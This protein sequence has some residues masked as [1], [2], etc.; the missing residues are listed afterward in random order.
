MS[1]EENVNVISRF[2][3]EQFKVEILEH[4]KLNG[5]DDVSLGDTLYF[6]QKSGITLKQV[7][8][9]MKSASLTTETGALQFMK[10]NLEMESKMGGVGGLAK[11]MLTSALTDETIT[12]PVYKGSGEIHLEP[13][14]GHFIILKLHN[15]EVVVDQ[16]IFY[17]CDS[18]LAVS[19]IRQKNLV[20]GLIGGEGL[21]Q[22]KVSG[23][24]FLV[25]K[26]PVPEIEIKKEV[27]NGETL[28]VDGSFALLRKGNVEFTIQKSSK[29]LIGSFT[30]GEGLLQTF[31]GT[32]EVWLAPTLPAYN[33]IYLEDTDQDADDS[34]GKLSWIRRLGTVKYSV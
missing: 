15:E 23:T 33:E 29:S 14:F 8:I 3:N 34:P 4:Q 7:R 18:K 6:A 12:R 17:C 24:G 5:T 16:G 26:V 22:T 20:T 19:V 32:G 21:F 1:F 28:H 10:G 31:K 30:S 11:K 9:T 13:S 2:D 27:L 25:V